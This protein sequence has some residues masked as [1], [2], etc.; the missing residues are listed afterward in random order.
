MFVRN[1]VPRIPPGYPRAGCSIRGLFCGL[2]CGLYRGPRCG[3]GCG[4]GSGCVFADPGRA[5]G[6]GLAGTAGCGCGFFAA[7]GGS[8]R[9][10]LQD[11]LP[12]GVAAAGVELVP[13]AQHAA[14]SS[15]PALPAAAHDHVRPCETAER[16]ALSCSLLERAT[17]GAVATR[18]PSSRGS[19]AGRQQTAEASVQS[20]RML[21]KNSHRRSN[22]QSE[23]FGH[24]GQPLLL[25]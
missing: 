2:C 4:C 8:R 1:L 25:L 6:Y 5:P 17:R 20:S 15:T 14:A 10:C 7:V 12:A 22:R 3:C 16:Q 9:C 23:Q 24:W 13:A 11:D 18:S 19:P 21:S